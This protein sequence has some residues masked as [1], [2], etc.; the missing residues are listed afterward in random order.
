MQQL[1]SLNRAVEYVQKTEELEFRFMSAVRRMKKAFNLCSASENFTD[2][3]IDKIHF[4]QAVRSVLYKLTKGEALD[5]EQMN[6][7]VRKLLE[8]AIQSDGI[9]ELFETGK[10]IDFDIFSDEY[11]ARIE[12][13]NLTNTKIK[14]LQILLSYAIMEFQRVNKIKSIEVAERMRAVVDTYNNRRKDEAFANEVLDDVA[15]QLADLIHELKQE[16][17]SF[18]KNWYR[19]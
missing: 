13:I 3:D 17:N 10:H 19:L 1:N 18:K 11:M 14:A 12:K 6:M 9:E 5:T 8:G 15:N 16:K 2:I 7:K 4:Y